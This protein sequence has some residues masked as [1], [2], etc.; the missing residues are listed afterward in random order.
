[1]V[2][3]GFRW[4]KILQQIWLYIYIYMGLHA[5]NPWMHQKGC[6]TMDVMWLYGFIWFYSTWFRRDVLWFLGIYIMLQ[7]MHQWSAQLMWISLKNAGCLSCFGWFSPE[8]R[9]AGRGIGGS[10]EHG[11]I[12]SRICLW[13]GFIAAFMWIYPLVMTN[14]TNVANWR[15]TIWK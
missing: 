14:V 13:C 10:V 3:H 4:L 11:K 5:R 9:W 7:L 12:P 2:L 1:M 8:L 15:I 6:E